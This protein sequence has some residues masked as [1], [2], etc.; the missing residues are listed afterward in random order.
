MHNNP[1]CRAFTLFSCSIPIPHPLQIQK[2]C[3]VV[4]PNQA[5]N[6]PLDNAKATLY[7]TSINTDKS[8][9]SQVRL[10]SLSPNLIFRTT[11]F[12]FV[13]YCSFSM[14][15]IGP[16][17]LRESVRVW[18]RETTTDPGRPP[19]SVSYP[20]PTASRVRPLTFNFDGAPCGH[21]KKAWAIYALRLRSPT[22]N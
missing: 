4:D 6:K 9:S 1:S 15:C 7:K 16:D 18:L 8:S 5:F 12:Y 2:L 19:D 21:T 3:R 10:I 17:P 22:R 13:T 11:P 20:G 14:Y